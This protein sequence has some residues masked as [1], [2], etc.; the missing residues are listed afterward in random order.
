MAQGSGV[1]GQVEQVTDDDVNENPE[2]IGVEVLE[3]RR[4][5]EEKVEEFKNQQLEG[6]FACEGGEK[7]QVENLC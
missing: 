7:K 2:V 6:C 5:G 4:V 1:G 3:S